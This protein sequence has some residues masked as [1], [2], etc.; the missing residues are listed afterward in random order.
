MIDHCI[1]ALKK[2]KLRNYEDLSFR[3][4]ITDA[5]QAIC[6]NTTHFVGAKEMFDYGTSLKKRWA[7]M[8][9]EARGDKKPKKKKAE[10][11]TRSAQEIAQDM[12]AKIKGI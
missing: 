8:V 6:E 5:L 11:D 1:A 9:E 3:V 2:E 7:E 12:W 10:D 4:Y